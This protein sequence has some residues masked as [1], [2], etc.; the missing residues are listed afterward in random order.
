MSSAAEAELP[1]LAQRPAVAPPPSM[2]R[3]LRDGSQFGHDRTFLAAP[4]GYRTS[5]SSGRRR[6]RRSIS[7]NLVGWATGGFSA[8][9]EITGNRVAELTRNMDEGVI[10]GVPRAP[11][12]VQYFLEWV[13]PNGQHILLRDS[14]WFSDYEILDGA[15]LRVLPVLRRLPERP[16][17]MPEPQSEPS[18]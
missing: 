17:Q 16:A 15:D 1:V 13:D 9:V 18:P 11:E 8:R 3:P 5:S 7:C 10:D 6:R 14:L 12:Y 2:D 4:Q